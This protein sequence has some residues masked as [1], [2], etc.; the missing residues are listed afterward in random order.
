MVKRYAPE[1]H[2]QIVPRTP[3]FS[4]PVPRH[5]RRNLV[6]AHAPLGTRLDRR[7]NRVRG[8]DPIRVRERVAVDRDRTPTESRD[9][10]LKRIFFRA[11]DRIGFLAAFYT[12][13]W[14]RTTVDYAPTG[15]QNHGFWIT[16]ILF[17]V[18][19]IKVL[20]GILCLEDAL[21]VL[22]GLFVGDILLDVEALVGG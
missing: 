2:H 19:A 13:R 21:H 8:V 11:R 4:R 1:T 15:T 14:K 22:A 7:D 12:H 17:Q 16:W 20:V 3:A 6:A 9:D 10:G 18:L 5:Q